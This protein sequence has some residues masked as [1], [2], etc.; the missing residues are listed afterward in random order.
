MTIRPQSSFK[1]VFILGLLA[2]LMPLSIDMYLPALPVISAQ[3]GVPAGSAQMTLSTY[4][5]G[6]ALGQLFYGPMA[7]SLGRKPVIL[8]GTLVFAAAAVACALAQTIDHLI[9]MRF[10]HGLAAAA[11]SVVINALMRDIYP[12]EEFSRMMSFVMLVTTIAPLVAPMAGGA[13]LVWFSWHVIFW[14]LALAAL[15]ASAMIFFFIDETLPVERRQKFHIRTTIGNFASL[16]RHKRVLS[17]MLASGF[18][19]AGMFSF[20]SAGPFVY[21]EL[22][23]VSPQHFGYYFAL[24]I[25]FLFIMTIINSRFVRRVGALNMFRAGLWIQFVM[26]IWLVVSAFLGVGFWALVVGVAAFVGC[27]SMVSSN[28]MA[29]ILDEFPHM[30]GTASSLAGT[31]RFGIGAIVGALL[32]MATFTTAWP[33]LW[34]M[35]F[36]A[37]SSILFYLYASRPRKAAH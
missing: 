2:M 18:S 12:K 34:A 7:D 22:N 28:A 3:F 9:I 15:L 36:C 26:A 31:F 16:F 27:V 24:N 23:H 17:Y 4:I 33:M 13:V 21:I 20:L 6:F 10:F 32:S 25:V 1:I 30:A 37:T 11:A 29:V 19:F 14:I 8:G 35:A 5:L